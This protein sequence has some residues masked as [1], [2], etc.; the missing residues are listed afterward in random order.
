MFFQPKQTQ[1]SDQQKKDEQWT[2]KLPGSTRIAQEGTVSVD[3]L[4]PMGR[5]VMRDKE[6]IAGNGEGG[7]P[8]EDCAGGKQ[9]QRNLPETG[10]LGS[11]P[12]SVQDPTAPEQAEEHAFWTRERQEGG[13]GHADFD[14]ALQV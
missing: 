2:G 4:L 3:S 8:P 10:A 11:L 5:P 14:T 12:A 1:K 9:R 6:W 13:N 7:R